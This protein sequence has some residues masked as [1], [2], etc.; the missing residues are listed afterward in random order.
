VGYVKKHVK[1]LPVQFSVSPRPAWDPRTIRTSRVEQKPDKNYSSFNWASQLV[2]S[3]PAPSESLRSGASRSSCAR[4][5]G[6]RSARRY[7]SSC[8]RG[9]SRASPDRF[10]LRPCVSR[11]CDESH[12]EPNSAR[13]G[14]ERLLAETIMR[15]IHPGDMPAGTPPRG[16]DPG[17][18]RDGDRFVD[19]CELPFLRDLVRFEIRTGSRDDRRAFTKKARSHGR[20]LPDP[21][22]STGW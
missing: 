22:R 13:P 12:R 8:G 19:V 18:L 3:A 7:G 10:P 4:P 9:F 14:L 2:R 15:V 16:K 5:S 6:E 1:I 17:R 20:E 11:R 21:R